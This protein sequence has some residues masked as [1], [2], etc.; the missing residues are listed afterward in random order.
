M[1]D[2]A[3][4]SKASKVVVRG[5]MADPLKVY[6]RLLKKSGRKVEL[7]SPLPKPTPPSP[8]QEKK[9]E[10]NKEPKQ[11]K[12]EEVANQKMVFIYFFIFIFDV[13]S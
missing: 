5:K 3:T 10:E 12:K 8:P 11:D 4:D 2:V 1:E 6:L 7:V 9:K 13:E